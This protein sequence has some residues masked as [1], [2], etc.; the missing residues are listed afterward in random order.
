MLRRILSF[1][2]CAIG[3][4]PAVCQDKRHTPTFAFVGDIMMGTTYPSV[5]L[6]S[7]DGRQLFVSAVPSLHKVDLAIGNLE[8]TLCDDGETKKQQSKVSYAFRTPSHYAER[9]KE[10]G[11]AYMCL[12][13]N[14][15]YDFGKYGVEST[16]RSLSSRGIAFSGLSELPMSV[17]MHRNGRKIGICSFGYN[18]YTLRHQ[19]LKLVRMI[20]TRLASSCDLVV[21]TFHGGGE[22]KAF[23]RIPEGTET[24]CGENRGNLRLFAHFCIDAGADIIV[25]HGPHVPRA[26]ELYK[27]H[28]IAYSLG[29]FCTPFG[30]S[31]MGV[32]GYAPLLEVKTDDVG[33]LV[34]ARVH[35]FIQRKGCGPVVDP[36]HHALRE[37]RRLT[38]LDFP[39]SGLCFYDDGRVMPAH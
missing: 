14:H 6:P 3:F 4:I 7:N 8:G 30:V 34:E 37:I 28:L 25:G 17:I 33:R 2:L 38:L 11:F 5:Q 10:A 21:A 16:C 36:D 22:G 20:I 9:L 29:N 12:A 35:S 27:H 15:I 39:K 23:S 18:H 19:N 32:S 1:I 24:F 13:N 31:I 26:M